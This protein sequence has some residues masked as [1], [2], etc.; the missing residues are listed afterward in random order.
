MSPSA[1]CPINRRLLYVGILSALVIALAHVVAMQTAWYVGRSGS[2]AVHTATY[3]HVIFSIWATAILLTPAL[4]FF[5]LF[6]PGAVEEYWRA[7]WTF[8]FVAF[9]FHLY[10]TVIRTFQLNFYEI[11]HSHSGFVANR[12]HTVDQ[13]AADFFLALWWFIDVI[14][15]WTVRWEVR[16]IRLQRGLLHLVTFVMFVMAFT[17]PK[18]SRGAHILGMV[19]AGAVLSAYMT[20]LLFRQP[21][22]KSFG[23][24]VFVTLFRI[25]NRI[26][27]V[28]SHRLVWHRMPLLFAILNLDGLREVLRAKNLHNTSDI[29]VTNPAGLRPPVP[30]SPA[31]LHSRE[32]D[33]WHNDLTKPDMG[34]ASLNPANP[35]DTSDFTLSRPGARFGRN[36]PL[37]EVVSET[38]ASLLEPNPWEVSNAL[39][40]RPPGHFE[41]A[42]SLNLLAAAW[43]QFQV[44]DWFNH[45]TP[46]ANDRIVVETTPPNLPVGC[47]MRIRRTRPD[48]TRDPNDGISLKT[49]VNAESHWWDGSQIYGSSSGAVARY[50]SGKDGRLALGPDGLLVMEESGF[51][52]TG[53]TA[54]SW[55]GLSLMHNLFAKEH[56][57]ICEHLKREYPD[58][59]DEQLYR[60]A[61]LVNVAL[62][63][64]IHTLDWT[65][66]I[67]GHPALK[68]GMKGNWWGFASER[69]KKVLRRISE[70]E[71]VS[72]IPGSVTNHHGTDFCLTEEFVS[73]YRMHALMPDK[74]ELY[75]VVDGTKLPRTLIL[76]AER[77]GDPSDA[78]GP[79]SRT[80]ALS[81][82]TMADLFYSFGLANPGA[83]VLHNYPEWMRRLPRRDDAGRFVEFIDL[84]AIDIV[85]DRE[86][87]VPRYNRF[88]ELFH[89]R[90]VKSFAQLTD[91]PVWAKE[92]EKVYG[93]VDKVDLMV[94]MY[95]ETPPRGFGISDTAFRLFILMASR[96]LKSD[97]FFTKDYTPEIYSRAGIDWVENNTM[98]TVLLR[99]Y[100]ALAPA[101]YDRENVFTPWHDVRNPPPRLVP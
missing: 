72:G 18:A 3:Y 59:D 51:E 47:P 29:P 36:I 101:L 44:H 81:A 57:A 26:R 6:R 30:Y 84:A 38:A 13:P 55:I 56:N 8:A 9:L 62:M 22:P 42:T 77:D 5:I 50:R 63:A 35:A 91:N 2:P 10:W 65:P 24:Y 100:P 98:R 76:G 99:H 37:N 70:G 90:P 21:D 20:R 23:V 46:D 66:A 39:L 69:I 45:G 61:R 32:P 68:V 93:D 96:R 14:L 33:G 17:A 79:F 43:I 89:M 97:R 12:E 60:T 27:I 80:H 73:V 92:L 88:R 34:S 74:I 67:L 16:W 7:F 54:N 31:Y 11:F 40:S 64:K 71:L 52:R 78:V 85:R 83:L 4:C 1:E 82:G 48:P 49:Y 25:I 86:R 15:L 87:G 75:A 28:M 94:G 95:A 19:M 41:P 58:W 53:L